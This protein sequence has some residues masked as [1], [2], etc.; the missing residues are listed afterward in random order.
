MARYRTIKPITTHPDSIKPI[1]AKLDCTLTL[2]KAMDRLPASICYQATH[3]LE[4]LILI[5]QTQEVERHHEW[6]SHHTLEAHCPLE[7]IRSRRH[8]KHREGCRA[9]R[10][11]QPA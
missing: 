1:S 10:R 8:P 2:S 5:A 6:A 11:A 9:T 3:Q 4:I 7:F